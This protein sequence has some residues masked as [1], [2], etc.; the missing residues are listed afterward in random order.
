MCGRF[1]RNRVSL[2][3]GVRKPCKPLPSLVCLPLACYSSLMHQKLF[4]SFFHASWYFRKRLCYIKQQALQVTLFW[5]SRNRLFFLKIVTILTYYPNCSE[6]GFS[7]LLVKYNLKSW[8][9]W[10]I[11]KNNPT[12][13]IT[14]VQVNWLIRTDW[15]PIEL[16][17]D[18]SLF[19]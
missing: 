9:T 15:C 1:Y 11:R 17:G 14:Y 8:I 5:N 4:C 16:R 10:R 18:K 19:E 3:Y 12:H 7:L 2:P 6:F 13:T